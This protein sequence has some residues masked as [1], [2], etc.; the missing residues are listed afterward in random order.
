MPHRI[1][2]RNALLVRNPRKK[3]HGNKAGFQQRAFVCH[4]SGNQQTNAGKRK[5]MDVRSTHTGR[6]W[7]L[8]CRQV[9]L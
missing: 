6:S 2:Q 4:L 1:F 8:R 7:L 9:A 5:L 3:G